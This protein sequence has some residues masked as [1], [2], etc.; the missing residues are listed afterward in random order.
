[1]RALASIKSK[2]NH[3]RT[4]SKKKNRKESERQSSSRKHEIR[5]MSSGA[6]T[7]SASQANSVMRDKPIVFLS[8]HI[9]ALPL[10]Y[11]PSG[12]M[13]SHRDKISPLALL[14]LRSILAADGRTALISRCRDRSPRKNTINAMIPAILHCTPYSGGIYARYK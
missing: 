11:C 6:R 10:T 2:S 8:S 7:V 12:I 3:Y 14:Y 1:V 4:S 9:A 5:S 13:I